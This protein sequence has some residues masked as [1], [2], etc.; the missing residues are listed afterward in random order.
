MKLSDSQLI[1]IGNVAA[2]LMSLFAVVITARYVGPDIFGFCSILIIILTFCMGFA[3]FGACAWAARELAAQKISALT[4]KSIMQT[5]T[6]LN[7]VWL[8]SIPIFFLTVEAQFKWACML[9]AYPF[10]WNRFN[11]NQQFLVATNQI[12]KSVSLIIVERMS[13]LTIIPLSALDVEKSLA[14]SAPILLGLAIHNFMGNKE[15]SNYK[16]SKIFSKKYTSV[17]LFRESRHFGLISIS[18]S[19]TN[20]DGFIVASIGSLTESANYVL[21]QRLRN[22]LTIVFSAFATRVKPIAAKRDFKLVKA[23]VKGEA[24]FLTYGVLTNLIISILA[25]FYSDMV[26]GASFEGINLLMFFGTLTAIP[27]GIL[28]ILT[29]ILSCFGAERFVARGTVVYVVLLFLVIGVSTH[30]YGSLGAVISVFMISLTYTFC[31]AVVLNNQTKR[32]EY[33]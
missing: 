5:K 12:K 31:C 25:Y 33:Q 20:L 3:D 17:G 13:W 10:L 19:M 15:F 28:L 2:G 1:V 30:F 18:G 9:F 29:N 4:F 14:F 11:Y 23:A 8:I 24:K 27:V 26:L 16:D 6:R 7:L 21:A 22:P 32:L